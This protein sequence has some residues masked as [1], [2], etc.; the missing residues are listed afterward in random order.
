MPRLPQKEAK[1]SLEDKRVRK[2]EE[3]G[4][5]DGAEG[6]EEGIL[7]QA[8]KTAKEMKKNGEPIEKIARYTG[9]SPEEIEKL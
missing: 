7:E 2:E 3:D 4:R 9:L 6:I 5:A 8:M 1:L